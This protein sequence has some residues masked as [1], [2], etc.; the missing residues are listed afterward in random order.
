MPYVQHEVEGAKAEAR[1][2]TMAHYIIVVEDVD[3]S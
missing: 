1:P 3:I 2:D